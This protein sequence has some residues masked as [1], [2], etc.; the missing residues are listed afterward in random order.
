MNETIHAFGNNVD[1]QLE[2]NE[3]FKHVYDNKK[4]VTNNQKNRVILFDSYVNNG[5]GTYISRLLI[6]F[7]FLIILYKILV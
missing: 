7:I 2:F 1:S 5:K 4:K 6:M 3:D